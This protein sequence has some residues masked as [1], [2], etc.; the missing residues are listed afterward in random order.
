MIEFV[1]IDFE[2]LPTDTTTPKSVEILSAIVQFVIFGDEFILEK[3]P[4][5]PVA[6]LLIIKELRIVGEDS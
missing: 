3:N 2:S 6:E 4:E 5:P 1:I